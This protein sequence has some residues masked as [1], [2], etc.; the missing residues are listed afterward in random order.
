[1]GTPE[2]WEC[3]NHPFHVYPPA[4]PLVC[5]WCGHRRSAADALVALVAGWKG[6]SGSMARALVA[7]HEEEMA[8]P[9]ATMSKD[10]Q[11]RVDLRV[12]FRMSAEE[13][14]SVLVKNT[15]PYW[16]GEG[17]PPDF[18]N[19]AEA[20]DALREAIHQWG[21]QTEGWSDRMTP[22]E[23]DSWAAWARQQVLLAY[24][25]LEG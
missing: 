3:E 5:R 15:A 25:E 12:P 23:T 24:P 14:G 10:G 22:E 17:M 19:R 9:K 21:E 16:G 18:T 8:M 11:M 1:M 4:D 13:L 20:K 7:A 2:G 6:W